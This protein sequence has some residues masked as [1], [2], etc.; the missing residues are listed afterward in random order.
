MDKK[1]LEITASVEKVSSLI[2]SFFAEGAFPL[3]IKLYPNLDGVINE[4]QEANMM[5]L[6][7]SLMDLAN[8]CDLGIERLS[9]ALEAGADDDD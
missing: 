4:E 7:D 3:L 1:I 5:L 8:V 9:E 2:D 6:R